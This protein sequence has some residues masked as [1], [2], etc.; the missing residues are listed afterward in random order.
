MN[1]RTENSPVTILLI[2]DNPGDVRLI[3][4]AFKEAK[5]TN[6]IHSVLNGD[7]GMIFLRK[8]GEFSSAQTPD[9]V[10]LDLNLPGKKGR[11]ILAEMRKDSRLKAIPV[12]V[13]S[14][15]YAEEDIVK[16]YELCANC[17]IT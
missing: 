13:L 7:D 16:S 4:E 10:I 15:S 9:L 17:Y 3:R 12:I 5:V 11:E 6:E 2:E 14:S 1:P 8:E